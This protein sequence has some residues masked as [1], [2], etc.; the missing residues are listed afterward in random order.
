M[1]PRGN[2]LLWLA[3][4]PSRSLMEE[5]NKIRRVSASHGASENGSVRM[6]L[7]VPTLEGGPPQQ[8]AQGEEMHH[9]RL[10]EMCLRALPCIEGL[11]CVYE[12]GYALV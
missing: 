8:I 6:G 12:K 9:I 5:S 2:N 7:V 1:F 4:N 11:R 3:Y 10:F